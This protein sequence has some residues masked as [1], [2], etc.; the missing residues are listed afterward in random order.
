MVYALAC[1][2]SLI[3]RNKA[4]RCDGSDDHKEKKHMKIQRMRIHSGS[5]QWKM[6]S[7]RRERQWNICFHSE[8]KFSDRWQ[9]SS[10]YVSYDFNCFLFALDGLEFFFFLIL[11]L[12]IER[13]NGKK[14]QSSTF[15]NSFNLLR[16]ASMRTKWNYEWKIK[17]NRSR[18]CS[19]FYYVHIGLRRCTDCARILRC[20]NR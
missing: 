1:E 11:W 2:P 7:A 14:E 3:Y 18:Q 13:R 6:S 20:P 16:F 5:N 12:K 8:F 19:E 10:P 4:A 15:A 9:C 17:L